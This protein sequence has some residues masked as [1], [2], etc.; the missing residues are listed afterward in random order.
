MVVNRKILMGTLIGATA[1][2]AA[3]NKTC[4]IGEGTDGI[5]PGSPED[6]A[7]N[8]PNTVYFDFDRSSLS[9]AAKKRVEAQIC[10]LNTYSGSRVCVAGHTDSRGTAEYNVA[11]GQRRANSVSKEMKKGGISDDRISIVSYGKERLVDTGTDEM[12]HAKNRRAVSAVE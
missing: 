4:K 1:F 11:L 2:L 12:A 10:W 5:V 9:E 7:T 3:C 6:F 8:V